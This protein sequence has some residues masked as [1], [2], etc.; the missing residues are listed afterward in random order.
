[1]TNICYALVMI[2]AWFYYLNSFADEPF[3]DTLIK[4][5]QD[6]INAMHPAFCLDK[7]FIANPTTMEMDPNEKIETFAVI[8]T[9][10][11]DYYNCEYTICSNFYCICNLFDWYCNEES[12][13]PRE[14]IPVTKQF[15]FEDV[16]CSL[17][18]LDLF[19]SLREALINSVLEH[20]YSNLL[21]ELNEYFPNVLSQLTKDF[22]VIKKPA[23]VEGLTCYNPKE[24]IVAIDGN[25]DP[26]L[27]QI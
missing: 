18:M 25:K 9:L 8:C 7:E 6:E 2:S 13:Y 14:T 20:G 22:L 26:Y 15:K 16:D 24:F 17:I 19:K 10:E 4:S 1:M 23:K 12:I 5:T 21:A 27:S 3:P 11:Y